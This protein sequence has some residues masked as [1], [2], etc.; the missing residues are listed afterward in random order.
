MRDRNCKKKI[1][2]RFTSQDQIKDL[3]FQFLNFVD[4]LSKPMIHNSPRKETI[5]QVCF[6]ISNG[7]S[8]PLIYHDKKRKDQILRVLGGVR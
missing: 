7:F 1:G 8:K 6:Y 5:K 3:G 2:Q 4:C